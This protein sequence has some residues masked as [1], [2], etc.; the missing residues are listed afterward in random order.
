M[1]EKADFVFG[2]IILQRLQSTN[3]QKGRQKRENPIAY[4]I[5]SAYNKGLGCS[6]HSIKQKEL[7]NTAHND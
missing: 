3:D 2:A 6:R 4:Y 1:G 7:E 5:C